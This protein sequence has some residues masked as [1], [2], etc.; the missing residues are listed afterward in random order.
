MADTYE[1]RND[2]IWPGG[3]SL[4]PRPP[5]LVYL[6]IWVYVRLAQ[7]A[8]GTGRRGYDEL[9]DAC[10]QSRADGR[11]LFPLSS[12]HIVELYDIASVD[13][14]RDLV[15]VMEEL[16]DFHCFLGL[17]Q[18]QEL[19]V[20]AAL[21]ELPTVTTAPQTS[22]ALIG[23]SVLYPFGRLGV[24][25][26][27]GGVH[28]DDAGW[29]AEQVCQDLGID[30]GADAMASLHRWMERQ[31]ITGP[32]NHNDPELR[33]Y[34]YTLDVR[35]NMLEQRAQQQRHLAQALDANPEMRRGRLRDWVNFFEMQIGLKEALGRATG[36]L[37]MSIIELLELDQL[38]E[39]QGRTK[40]RDFSD[41]MPSTR[42]TVSAKERYHRDSFHDWTSNDLNDI[43]ALAIAVP[44]CHA[45][46]T[47][48]AARNVVDQAKE[49]RV[50]GT[51]LPRRP[52]QLIDWLDDLPATESVQR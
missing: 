33:S 30:P 10:Q 39:Q 26:E 6:D 1:I 32:E 25:F 13:Q 41:R 12:T 49:L 8:A 24:G 5:A 22:L 23:P 47:D 15:A 51:F 44:Y 4:P 36:T 52:Q 11:A 29:W 31:L 28:S 2:V 48:K 40:L 27:F 42:V 46:Y 18:I 35:R 9:L 20:E 50:F 3:L 45:V 37:N 14:R 17:P 34:G 38:P 19:E 43:D 16:S 7:A 21:A